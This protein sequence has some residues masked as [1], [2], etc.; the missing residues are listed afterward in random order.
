MGALFSGYPTT[1]RIVFS[2][3]DFD[4]ADSIVEEDDRAMR[5]SGRGRSTRVGIMRDA[6]TPGAFGE[7]DGR[8]TSVPHNPIIDGEWMYNL[9]ALNQEYASRKKSTKGHHDKS[10]FTGPS[11]SAL[12]H[13]AHGHGHGHSHGHAQR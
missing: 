3:D 10:S 2:P 12:E 9:D 4:N 8:Q 5:G 13:K 11:G 6:G 1:R 7:E